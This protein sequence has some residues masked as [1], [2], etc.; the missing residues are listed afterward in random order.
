MQSMESSIQWVAESTR[1]FQGRADARYGVLRL[2]GGED[3]FVKRLPKNA[4]PLAEELIAQEREV[5]DALSTFDVAAPH[6]LSSPLHD[7]TTL[8]SEFAGVSLAS[9]VRQESLEASELVVV[10]E[11]VFRMAAQY[12]KCGVLPMDVSGANVVLPLER[13]L[14]GGAVLLCKPTLVDHAMTLV[15][16]MTRRRPIWMHP[17]MQRVAPELRTALQADHDEML[18]AFSAQGCRPR[19]LE[20]LSLVEFEAVRRCYGRFQSRQ[21]LQSAIDAGLTNVDAAMQYSVGR[22]IETTL[23][24]LSASTFQRFS[25]LTDRLCR[26]RWQDRFPSLDAACSEWMSVRADSGF[27][28]LSVTH[29]SLPP[30]WTVGTL[31]AQP[32]TTEIGDATDGTFLPSDVLPDPATHHGLRAKGVSE[33]SSPS[34]RAS[35][36]A[37]SAAAHSA[38]RWF[39]YAVATLGIAVVLVQTGVWY[40]WLAPAIHRGV[41]AW[42]AR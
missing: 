33:H 1:R 28:S 17:H 24:T 23:G 29:R 11:S 34:R 27:A 19:P 6:L 37:W 30:V 3:A 14:D 31:A 2:P 13:G 35:G 21:L 39:A 36:T 4:N 32:S 42:I 15:P 26:E 9:L 40:G 41:G 16:G 25:H 18:E 7:A 22:L 5:L 8:V 38:A 10:L 20:E 12:A